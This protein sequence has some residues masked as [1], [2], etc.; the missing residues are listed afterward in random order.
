[1]VTAGLLVERNYNQS[2]KSAKMCP[3]KQNIQ[4]KIN[5][6]PSKSPSVEFQLDKYLKQQANEELPHKLVSLQAAS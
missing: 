4:I 3:H 5:K 1:M 2:G 6:P